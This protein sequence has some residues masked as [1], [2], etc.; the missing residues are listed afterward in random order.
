MGSLSDYAE[1]KL[2]DHV[3]KVA[4]FT[5]PT[6][7]YIALSTADPLDDGSGLTE[8]SGGAYA[9]V[10]CNTWDTAASRKTANTNQ[11]N[12]PAATGSA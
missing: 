10:L 1:G 12:F 3:L 7:I 9:R 4:A 6:N 2:L 8:P 5:V 11:A